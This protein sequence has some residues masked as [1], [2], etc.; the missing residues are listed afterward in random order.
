MKRAGLF[1]MITGCCTLL[2]AGW[3]VLGC[4]GGS[5]TQQPQELADR[6][7]LAG[8]CT[9]TCAT[10]SGCAPWLNEAE[11][12]EHMDLCQ[13]HCN[14]PVEE[15]VELRDCTLGCEKELDCV[16]YFECLCG[17]GLDGVCF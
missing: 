10:I 17:C 2:I 14:D 11:H 13:A 1:L 8:V 3:T 15:D 7:S 6:A 12:N 16:D 9:D 4:G 5:D